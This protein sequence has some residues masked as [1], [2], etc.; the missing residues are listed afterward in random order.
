MDMMKFGTGTKRLFVDNVEE[1]QTIIRI[2]PSGAGERRY[3]EV[4]AGC[5]RCTKCGCMGFE[6]HTRGDMCA[7]CGHNRATHL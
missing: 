1:M 6:W 3:R 4:R 2:K 7:N 5:G